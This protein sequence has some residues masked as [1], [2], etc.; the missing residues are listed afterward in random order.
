MGKLRNLNSSPGVYFAFND[1]PY[2]NGSEEANRV[3]KINVG[4]ATPSVTGVKG[5]QYV[6]T[7]V[8]VICDNIPSKKGEAEIG[9]EYTWDQYVVY[10]DGSSAC[11]VSGMTT[12]ASEIV[13]NFTDMISGVTIENNKIEY[14]A[15]KS[16]NERTLAKV[17]I[18]VILD[19][20]NSLDGPV[21]KDSEVFEIKQN[22]RRL[23][24]NSSYNT[25]EIAEG[26]DDITVPPT[27]SSVNIEYTGHTIFVYDN[28]EE[29]D[30]P[31]SGFTASRIFVQNTS[32]EPIDRSF[33][34]TWRNDSYLSIEPAKKKIKITQLGLIGTLYYGR[35]PFLDKEDGVPI[36]AI[37]PEKITA[38]LS[39]FSTVNYTNV[40]YD[41][42]I[43]LDNIKLYIAD[44]LLC[45]VP[46]GCDAK[47]NNI[48]VDFNG[49][50][51]HQKF[52]FNNEE[53][54]DFAANGEVTK[55]LEGTKYRIYGY[56]AMDN[57]ELGQNTIVIRHISQ[58]ED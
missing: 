36:S 40:S 53:R 55:I 42:D 41:T 5:Y 1:I 24:I 45:L 9:V 11:S 49:Q 21:T 43:V 39:G 25:I 14:E 46:D 44:Y 12:G 6:I 8:S 37:T 58:P 16:D 35:L 10:E 30:T 19:K 31:F 47:F 18:T 52:V 34:F 7:N 27:A 22:A 17:V 23:I 15:N 57:Q 29:I 3:P 20:A 28:E 48:Y 4:G 13:Y 56:M 2:P 38:A 32:Y 50:K 33:E 26:K 54:S 51:H